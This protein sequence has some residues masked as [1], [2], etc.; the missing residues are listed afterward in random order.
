MA[1]IKLRYMARKTKD[2]KGSSKEQE[3]REQE[4]QHEQLQ[5]FAAF[6]DIWQ[7]LVP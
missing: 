6:R 2:K 1:V 5:L 7:A 4:F 3:N